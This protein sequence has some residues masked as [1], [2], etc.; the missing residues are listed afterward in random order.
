VSARRKG[1]KR[2]L[3]VLYAA[4]MRQLSVSEV[5]QEE[6]LRAER[7]PAREGS[8]A[9][10]REI[11]EGVTTHATEIDEMIESTSSWPM[12]RM[13]SIDRAILK[14]A[15]SELFVHPDI[16]EAVII[17]EA[18]ELAS[19]YSTDESRGFIQGV[20]GGLV[21]KIRPASSP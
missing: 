18:G 5:L 21:K 12:E 11:L 20:L 19:E 17:A 10:A 3:D 15:V 7:E 8:W 4:D 2:A 14:L 6:A 9:F 16:P 13:P 1:R